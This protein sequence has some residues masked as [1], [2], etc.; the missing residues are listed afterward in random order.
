MPWNSTWPVGSISVKANRIVGQQNTTY[1]ETIMGNSPVGT[2]TNTTR[3]HFWNVG[4]NEDGRHRFINSPV[5]T[6]GGIAADPLVGSG[7]DAVLYLK[8][9]NAQPQWFTRTSGGIIYQ[10]TPNILTGSATISS[11]SSYQN[12]VAVPDNTYGEIF[13]YTTNNN[14]YRFGGQTGFFVTR[15]GI[16]SAW[17]ISY[18]AEG[19]ATA[20]SGLKFGNGADTSL[21]NIRVRRESTNNLNTNWNY[22]ITYRAL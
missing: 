8:M 5:F 1:I 12:L 22:I 17:A 13:M 9:T 10:S 3:D 21:L 14:N 4:S 15:G 16:V 20:N 2:N 7:M 18:Q 6:V 11:S 19:T